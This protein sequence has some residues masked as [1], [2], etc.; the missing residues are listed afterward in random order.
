MRQTF[1]TI[2]LITPVITLVIAFIPNKMPL[3]SGN[4]KPSPLTREDK[5]QQDRESKRESFKSGRDL[6]H[7][8]GV[9]F[10]PDL[11]LEPGFKKKLAPMFAA[12][13]E[14]RETRLVGKQIE[15]V[16][17]ADTLFLPEKVELTGDTVIL[18]NNLIFSGRNVVIKGPHD[19]HFFA[20]GRVQSVDLGAQRGEG[21]RSSILIKAGFIKAGFSKA[22]FDAAKRLGQLVEPEN[23]TL[24]V[25]ALGRD[26]WLASQKA[27]S[28]D[29]RNNHHARSSNA[30]QENVD[31]PPGATGGKGPDGTFSQIYWVMASILRMVRVELTSILI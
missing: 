6:L 18:A 21:G 16:Q 3:V 12:M 24:N 22:R 26:E 30:Q 23:I 5:Q 4:Q 19:L 25:D 1:L 2:C 13:P 7:K 14:F 15:G 31:Q 9:P 8:Y 29:P 28:K 11:L 27:A 10:D 20:M 17:L